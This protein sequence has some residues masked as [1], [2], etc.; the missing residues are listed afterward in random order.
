MLF[1][2]ASPQS[3]HPERSGAKRNEV[4]GSTHQFDHRNNRKCEDPSTRFVFFKV[5][6]A[7]ESF[8]S[9]ALSTA[10]R[11]TRLGALVL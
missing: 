10:L 11:M 4:E 3:C 2:V 6:F 5:R 7:I 8:E 9:A 1:S